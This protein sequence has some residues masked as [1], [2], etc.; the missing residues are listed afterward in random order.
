MIRKKISKNSKPSSLASSSTSTLDRQKIRIKAKHFQSRTITDEIFD[1]IN[2]LKTTDDY[3]SNLE[4]LS[5]LFH[6]IDTINEFAT[7]PEILK[8]LI[9]FKMDF[10]ELLEKKSNLKIRQAIA[11]ILCFICSSNP[12]ESKGEMVH[13]YLLGSNDLIHRWGIFFVR[14]L[15][16]DL[17]YCWKECPRKWSNIRQESLIRLIRKCSMFFI[18]QCSSI[19]A[20]DLLLETDQQ[21][22]LDELISNKNLDEC[23][24]VCQYISMMSV[25]QQ[26]PEN[27]QNLYVSLALCLRCNL[28]IDALLLA[29][30]INRFDLIEKIFLLNLNNRS[31]R[32]QMAL[33]LARHSIAINLHGSQMD[34]ELVNLLSNND[35]SYHFQMFA[36]HLDLCRPRVPKEI[37]KKDQT[38][39][40]LRARHERLLQMNQS[41]SILG[42]TF[43]NCFLNAC[44][45]S[46]RLL[47]TENA[48][49]WIGRHRDPLDRFAAVASLG[50]LCLWDLN[51]LNKIDKFLYSTDEHIK[52]GALLA[53]GIVNCSIRSEYDPA[54]L[55]L[56]S[57]V[58][59]NRYES[60]LKRIG[61]VIGLGIAYHGTNH[62][63]A[64]HLIHDALEKSINE[65]HNQTNTSKE[66]FPL[67]LATISLGLIG[68]STTNW[69]TIDLILKLIDRK[70]TKLIEWKTR[71]LIHSIGLLV[72][73]DRS[74][75][76]KLNNRIDQ[77]KSIDESLRRYLK[78]CCEAF[79]YCGSS[80]IL[81]VQGFIQN[82]LP[83]NE[84]R[85]DSS[86]DRSR[87]M[88]ESVLK[89]INQSKKLSSSSK[90]SSQKFIPIKSSSTK[91]KKDRS[92]RDQ[93][94]QNEP[95]LSER[96]LIQM[97]SIL[98]IGLVSLSDELNREMIFR[99]FGNFLKQGDSFLKSAT[100][101]AIA[102][103][104]L[105]NPKL[106]II[107]MLC[108]YG[109]FIDE[110]I[111]INSIL[112]LGLV[113]AGTNNTKALRILL[114]LNDFHRHRPNCLFAIK[115]ALGLLHLGKGILSL[116]PR[117]ETPLLR[118]C[119]IGSMSIFLFS[120]FDVR[121]FLQNHHYYLYFLAGSIRSKMLIA[122]NE[123]DLKPMSLSVRVGQSIDTVGTTG[124]CLRSVYAYQTFTTPVLL[125]QN[126]KAEIVNNEC[127]EPLNPNLQGFVIVREKN[128]SNQSI[129]QKISKE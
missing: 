57:Y 80:N 9:R 41:K 14:N 64:Y 60:S 105:S 117:M 45:S 29:I 38:H 76:S 12:S 71:D 90:S 113:C 17:I 61:S 125:N 23:R 36:K 28:Q 34:S 98:G 106:V 68:Q 59:S 30:Q 122:L 18:Q 20:C 99:T 119:S 26:E 78:I 21:I 69:S 27:E 51:S 124:P 37:F 48:M 67:N 100:F 62:Q 70:E 89:K 128:L 65:S 3:S 104:N 101:L 40:N 88:S 31:V 43:M 33:I 81:K 56:S 96:K 49:K 58:R 114:K 95:K 77:M 63:D 87:S 50:F 46:D 53:F 103:T 7:I 16:E 126:E 108:K 109:H 127:F 110:I 75:L 66:K 121:E 10:C 84:L 11:D 13:Y 115:I 44:F 55:M 24:K 123:N 116:C 35:L 19:E 72:L 107:E 47:L 83:I 32:N 94:D 93:K 86:I 120:L 8:I 111:A 15:A 85:T 129:E 82:C 25:Y 97:I 5:V 73:G 42:S 92:K 39:R 6:H 52:G 118:L 4:T 91:R 1:L 54:F 79:A 102:L 112:S 22:F 74:V 2:E